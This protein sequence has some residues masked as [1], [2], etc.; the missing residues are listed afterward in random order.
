[1]CAL[2]AN[3]NTTP[4]TIALTQFGGIQDE[5]IASGIFSPGHF[6]KMDNASKVLKHSTEGGDDITRIATEPVLAGA[7]STGFIGGGSIDT[8]YAVGDNAYYR[9]PQTG[10]KVL[11]YLKPGANYAVGDQLIHAGDGTLKKASAVTS[12]VT[13]K[14]IVGVVEVALNLS[15]SGAVSA[16]TTVRVSA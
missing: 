15:A 16:R 11:A 14:K 1:M 10:E 6:L 2:V 3:P 9:I 7:G 13:V 8:A 5:A 12:G 4:R